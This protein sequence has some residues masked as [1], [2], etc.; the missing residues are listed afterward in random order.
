[1]SNYVGTSTAAS[2][3]GGSVSYDRGVDTTV[4]GEC[5]YDV[6]QRLVASYLYNLPNVHNNVGIVGKALSGWAA[7]GVTTAQK[8]QPITLSDSRGG[9]V[10]GA[11]GTSGANLCPGMTTANVFTNGPIGS[12]LSDYFNTSAFCAPPVVGAINGVGGAT[13]YGNLGLNPVLGPGQFNWDISA[14][15]RM[16]VGGLSEHAD[17]EFRTDFFNA[18]NHP[19]FS[20]PASNVGSASTFG[21]ITTTSVGPRIIQF[22]L[23]YRF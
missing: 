5:G 23:K 14:Q 4:K 12:R 22:A 18:F 6:P 15:K 10:Y 19:Q 11:V 2:G 20:N 3:Q 21:V 16:E 7:A 8:G 1:L 17:L 13:G 9:Q